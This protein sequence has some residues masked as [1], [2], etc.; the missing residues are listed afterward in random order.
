MKRFRS[1]K[2]VKHSH[3]KRESMF[4]KMAVTPTAIMRSR[5]GEEVKSV[6]VLKTITSFDDAG[7]FVLLNGIVEGSSYYQRIGRRIRMKSVLVEG[8]IIID[9]TVSTVADYLRIILVYDR[10]PNG[11][12][13]VLSDL[14]LDQN[15]AGS[16]EARSISGLNYNNMSRFRILRD[17][18]CGTP[19]STTASAAPEAVSVMQNQTVSTQRISFYVDLRGLETSYQLTTGVIGAI[20]TGALYIFTCGANAAASSPYSFNFKS[21]VRYFD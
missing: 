14:L 12:T 3:D 8:N 7:A 6:D 17:W 4:K 1:G 21:R 9:G 2:R 11:S 5:R 18:Q 13:P 19:D 16:T 10:Q 20:S 15:Q